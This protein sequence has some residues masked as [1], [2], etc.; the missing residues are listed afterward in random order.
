M[1][2]ILITGPESSGK[3]TLAKQLAEALHGRFWP[4]YAREWLKARDGQYQQADLDT[5]L[6][7]Q[8]KMR[9]A[10]LL[11][12]ANIPHIFDT[13]PETF[14]TWSLIKYGSISPFIESQLANAH[15]DLVLLLAPDIPWQADP[16]RES[17][18][19]EERMLIFCT[20]AGRMHQ[21][22]W[23][24]AIIAGENRLNMALEIIRKA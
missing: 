22:G 19:L 24:F 14:Y 18:N 16:L 8:T 5:M 7:H 6:K 12:L 21:L 10:E 3:T 4:E 17:P 20:S 15:Y 13:G 9:H 11:K 23:R 2:R 1:I